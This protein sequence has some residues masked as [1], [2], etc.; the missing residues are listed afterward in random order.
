[1]VQIGRL[2]LTTWNEKYFASPGH[3]YVAYAP[4]VSRQI[5]AVHKSNLDTRYKKWKQNIVK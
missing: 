5:K 3:R 4:E 1:M 2:P